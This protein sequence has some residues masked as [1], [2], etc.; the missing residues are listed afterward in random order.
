VFSPAFAAKLRKEFPG[1][2]VTASIYDT[3]THCWYSLHPSIHITTASVIKAQVLG[4]VLLHAQDEH[5]GLDAFER[6]NI[7]P[8][9]RWSFNNPYVPRLYSDVGNV[10]GMNSFDDR[11]GA[12]HTTNTLE[13]G[14]TVTTASDRTHIAW[15]MLSG[16]GPLRAKYRKI[17]WSYMTHVTA[18]QRWGITAGVPAGYRV[19]LKNGFYPTEGVAAWRVGSTGFI[20]RPGRA[21]GYAITV[22]TDQN[23]SQVQGIR[24]VERVT[25]RAAS[26][27]TQGVARHRYVDRARCVTAHSGQSWADVAKLVHDSGHAEDVQRVSGGNPSPL[28]GQRV[29]SP[30]LRPR[31]G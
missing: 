26:R 19:A 29:C 4:A 8:M 7:H 27:L 13:Y 17:A 31:H 14:G 6:D 30:V 20:K 9:I 5:R 11:M 24:L 18:T 16:G 23:S 1:R 12:H 15:H 10:A 28:T 3:R 21:G 25:R 22:M 2:R